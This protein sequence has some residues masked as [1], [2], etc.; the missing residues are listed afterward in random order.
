[1]WLLYTILFLSVVGLIIA[2]KLLK[3][4]YKGYCFAQ[5]RAE[6]A[7]YLDYLV[8]TVIVAFISFSIAVCTLVF[9]ITIL[10]N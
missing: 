4:F 5:S 9:I 10:T 2:F 8:W 7:D 6:R 3:F 1:M